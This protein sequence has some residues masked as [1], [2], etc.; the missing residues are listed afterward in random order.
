MAGYSFENW[1]MRIYV[2]LK[3]ILSIIYV[4]FDWISST[5]ILD[6]EI[7]SSYPSSTYTKT[8]ILLERK[9]AGYRDATT[10]KD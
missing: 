5:T 9:E 8:N 7:G 1:Y 3:T 2:I 4:L 10:Y 6:V